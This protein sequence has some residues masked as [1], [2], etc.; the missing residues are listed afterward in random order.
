MPVDIVEL[1]EIY[2]M[3]VVVSFGLCMFISFVVW[4]LFF[5]FNFFR[6]IV[7]A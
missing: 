7:S 5:V 4:A 1:M 6:N 2:A 3:M